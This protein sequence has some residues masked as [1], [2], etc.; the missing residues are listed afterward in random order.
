MFIDPQAKEDRRGSDGRNP[1]RKLAIHLLSAR[2]NRAKNFFLVRVYK[3]GTPSG[4][5][6]SKSMFS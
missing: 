6:N 1:S 3:H 2:P 4:V 5:E